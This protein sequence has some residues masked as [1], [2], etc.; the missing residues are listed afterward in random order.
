MIIDDLILVKDPLSYSLLD[1][2]WV[3]SLSFFSGLASYVR[4]VRLGI[5]CHCSISTLFGDVVISLFVGVITF[6]LCEYAKIPLLLTAALIGIMSHMGNRA[7]FIVEGAAYRA[8][9]R[10]INT[11]MP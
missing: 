2:A 10:F 7:I 3:F 1:Y 11:K 4:K 5:I 6:Y 8:L 9:Q